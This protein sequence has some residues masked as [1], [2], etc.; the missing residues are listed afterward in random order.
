VNYLQ[1]NGYILYYSDHRGMLPDPNPTNGGGIPG[2]VITGESGLEDSVNAAQILTST[3]PDG[4]L[5]PKTYYGYSPEDVDQNGFLDNWGG[6]NIGYGFGVNTNTAPPNPY[7]TIAGCNTTGLTNSVSGARHVLKLVAGGMNAAGTASYL[8]ILPPAAACAFTATTDCGGFTVASENPVYVQGD[9]NSS[10]ADTFWGGGSNNAVHSAASIVADS[11]TL[12]SSISSWPVTAATTGWTDLNSLT[13][14]NTM[15]NRNASTT[16]YRMAVSGGKNIPFPQPGWAGVAKD[17][18]TDG[19]LHNFLRLLEDWSG[20][21]LNY[22][23]SLVNMY[24]SEYNT[25]TFKCCTMVYNAPVRNFYFDTLFL[26]PNN[27]PPGTPMFQDI[28][29]LSYHQNFTPQ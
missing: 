3:N 18:G 2:G 25:G 13:N 17:F 27:L 11:V 10:A 1:D 15:T 23:G 5:E 22:N 9:Y 4:L 7:L 21:N 14:F 20:V 24:Y 28:V 16:Y 19:G 29:N 6:K 8:P 26:N 12:L